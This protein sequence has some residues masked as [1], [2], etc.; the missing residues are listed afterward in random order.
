[1]RAVVAATI[2]KYGR[3]DVLVNNAGI[4][5]GE[6]PETMPLE[7][8]QRVLETN[9]TGAFLFSQAAGAEMLKRKSGAII[10]IAS[11]AGLRSSATDT[12]DAPA[13]AFLGATLTYADVKER[14][15]RLATALARAGIAKN[16]RVGI[17]LPN[18]PQYLI[19]AFAILRIGGIV[20]NVNPLYTP[21]EIAVV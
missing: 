18:C 14:S 6:R 19:A 1:V 4:S 10:N 16:D 15:D 5:W 2:E 20:V 12:P 17:M 9:L 21:R 13:T 11:V 3:V 8:W 7:Q